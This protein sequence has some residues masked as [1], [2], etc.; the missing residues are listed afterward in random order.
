MYR[1]RLFWRIQAFSFQSDKQPDK[2]T[3]QEQRYPKLCQ[4]VPFAPGVTVRATAMA[5]IQ[6]TATGDMRFQL[7]FISSG[8]HGCGWYASAS[9][10]RPL[11]PARSAR[12]LT[13]YPHLQT[14]G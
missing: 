1:R 4:V 8:R 13:G 14:E 3:S 10:N 6:F 2:H 12:W 11:I 5:G 7:L 9:L